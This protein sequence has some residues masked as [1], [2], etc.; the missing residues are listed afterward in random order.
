MN[1]INNLPVFVFAGLLASCG[2]IDNLNQPLANTGNNPLDAPGMG[3]S[4]SNSSQAMVKSNDYGFNIGEIVEVVI[5]NTALFDKVPKAGDSYKKILTLGDTLRVIGGEKD[6]IKVLTKDGEVG[7]VSSVMV[8]TQGLLTDIPPLD[9]SVTAVGANETPI[10]PDIAPDPKVKGIGEPDIAPGVDPESVPNIEAPLK[11][12]PTP[13]LPD[14]KPVVPSIPSGP[15]PEPS[16]P[17][18]PE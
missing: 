7:Y 2:V 13:A 3:F 1:F 6:F 10:I 9:P 14:P 17:G 11:V 8:V 5:S 16:N 12:E 15:A 4:N 18:L